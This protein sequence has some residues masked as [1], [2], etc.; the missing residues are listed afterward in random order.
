MDQAATQV[1]VAL[2]KITREFSA[3]N[4]ASKNYG[5]DIR[6]SRLRRISQIR[7]FPLLVLGLRLV[8]I[9]DS[10]TLFDI[11]DGSFIFRFRVLRIEI[12]SK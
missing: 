11:N 2:K 1:H 4:N 5:R 7:K 10:L 3:A 8:F 12:S 6:S 9:V